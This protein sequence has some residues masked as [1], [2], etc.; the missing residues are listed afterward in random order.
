MLLQSWKHSTGENQSKDNTG[1]WAQLNWGLKNTGENKLNKKR[2][3]KAIRNH[4][5]KY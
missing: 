1:Q 5:N 2:V 3:H 4:D